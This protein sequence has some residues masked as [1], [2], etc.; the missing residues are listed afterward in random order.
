MNPPEEMAITALAPWFGSK[1]NLSGAI[2]EELGEHRV[3]WEPMCGSM[4]VLL[5]KS[6][7]VMETANDMHGDLVNLARVVACPARGP[8]LFER[9]SRTLMAEPL[10]AESAAVINS[11]DTVDDVDPDRAFHYFVVAWL[12]RN[13]VAGTSSYNHHF[14]VRYTANGGHAAKRWRSAIDSMPAW[15]D[16]LRNVTILRRDAFELLPRIEDKAGTAIYVDPPYFTKGSYYLHDFGMVSKASQDGQKAKARHEQ[17]AEE[18]RRFKKAR[19]VLSYYDH[20]LLD[21]LYPSFGKRRIEVSKALAHQGRRG[22]NDTKAVEVL[23]TN[24][25]SY[26]AAEERQS[27]FP[28]T[29]GS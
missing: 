9:L 2:L 26:V 18:L 4:A 3:Y 6:P 15:H 1:R 7:C 24:G 10:F 16:R 14:C 28:V 21:E 13:G 17:L 12:G 19:V 8:Q 25:P 27:L 11:A 20:P 22:S 5:S 29:T 23:L